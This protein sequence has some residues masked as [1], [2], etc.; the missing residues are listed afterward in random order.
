[1][2]NV[3]KIPHIVG[4]LVVYINGL[5]PKIIT[6]VI[7]L[8]W[9]NS[10]TYSDFVSPIFWENTEKLKNCL[11]VKIVPYIGQ[12][13]SHGMSCSSHQT[14][15]HTPVWYIGYIG[16]RFSFFKVIVNRDNFTA[17]SCYLIM[18]WRAY[19]TIV[20]LHLALQLVIIRWQ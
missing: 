3:L 11:H 9:R 12:Q 19:S 13:L 14:K 1:M 17:W 15:T 7:R 20:M 6:M 10:K 8:Y 16:K 5:H 18:Q 2:H 4:K